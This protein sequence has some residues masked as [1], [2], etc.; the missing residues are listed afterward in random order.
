MKIFLKNE[1]HGIKVVT[2]MQIEVGNLE[3]FVDL[4]W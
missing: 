1:I 3:R 2:E 4:I